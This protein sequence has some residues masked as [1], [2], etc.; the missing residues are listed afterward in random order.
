MAGIIYPSSDD[1][2]V[3][4]PIQGDPGLSG[5]PGVQGSPGPPGQPF[6]VCIYTFM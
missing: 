4:I 3:Y 1:I 5:Y 2:T 6:V